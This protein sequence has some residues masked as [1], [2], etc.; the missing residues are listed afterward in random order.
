M[1]VQPLQQPPGP[2]QHPLQKPLHYQQ[3]PQKFYPSQQIY[4]HS[5]GQFL[6]I[7]NPAPPAQVQYINTKPQPPAESSSSNAAENED[8]KESEDIEE[9]N[10][11][12]D[13]S[14]EKGELNEENEDDEDSEEVE[15]YRDEEEDDE[16]KED[17]PKYTNYSFHFHSLQTKPNNQQKH[18]ESEDDEEEE[19][20]H[21]GGYRTHENVEEDEEEDS[22]EDSS[23]LNYNKYNKKVPK[24][25][26]KFA[27]YEKRPQNKYAYKPTNDKK[28]DYERY[29][30]TTS[31]PEIK[32]RDHQKRY[33][34]HYR[35]GDAEGRPSKHVPTTTKHMYREKWFIMKKI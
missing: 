21:R 23:R 17:R 29:T 14:E 27:K 28:F 3:Q 9:E 24:N 5:Q 20:D 7:R 19:D 34:Q 6:P 18:K 30:F 25:Y 26:T 22:N 4:P 8:E 31:R 32:H 12:S 35:H 16:E 13:D 11:D 1:H 33:K 2:L 10:E 15:R